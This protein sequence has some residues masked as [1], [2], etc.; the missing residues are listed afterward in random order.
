[1]SF[2]GMAQLSFKSVERHVGFWQAWRRTVEGA[3]L[4]ER[5]WQVKHPST[6]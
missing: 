3:A 4:P 2:G 1:M 6:R 5:P